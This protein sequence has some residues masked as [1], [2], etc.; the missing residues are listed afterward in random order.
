MLKRR[1]RQ[2]PL[3]VGVA[4]Y[5]E[6]CYAYNEECYALEPADLPQNIEMK[7]HA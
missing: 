7:I 5:N 3:E 6:E 2:K 4:L 1:A